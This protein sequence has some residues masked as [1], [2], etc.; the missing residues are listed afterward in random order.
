MGTCTYKRLTEKLTEDE[1]QWYNRHYAGLTATGELIQKT[2]DSGA[3]LGKNVITKVVFK[4]SWTPFGA[5]R[6]CGDH[7]I[8]ALYSSYK[9]IGKDLTTIKT[10][11]EDA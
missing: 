6:D 5:I 1:T 10:D 7:Y 3:I 9:W 8:E 2:Y 11:V 4:G